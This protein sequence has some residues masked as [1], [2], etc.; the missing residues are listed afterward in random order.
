MQSSSSTE[1]QSLHNRITRL[2]C[3]S[4]AVLDEVIRTMGLWI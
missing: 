1:G 4:I 3:S 2:V